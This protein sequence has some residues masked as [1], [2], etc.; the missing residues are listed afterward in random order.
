MRAAGVDRTRGAG[1]VGGAFGG[2]AT[3]SLL[4]GTVGASGYPTEGGYTRAFALCAAALAIG[5]VV[6]LA[7]P[8]RRPEASFEPHPVGDPI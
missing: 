6:G 8:Q 4:A 5:V 1:A 7:I 3:A 2:A